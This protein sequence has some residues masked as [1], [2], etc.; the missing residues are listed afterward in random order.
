MGGLG[1]PGGPSAANRTWWALRA[2]LSSDRLT[3]MRL[4]W[5]NPDDRFERWLG[6]T[7]LA[8]TSLSPSFRK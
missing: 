3:P 8:S 7:Q 4:P 2:A 1:V 6:F 5:I